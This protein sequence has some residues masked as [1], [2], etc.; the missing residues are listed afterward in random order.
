ML[1]WSV[2]LSVV[3]G[4]FLSGCGSKGDAAEKK[5]TFGTPV[6][7][8]E[9]Y[10]V[11]AQPLQRIYRS[12]GN[13]VPNEAINVYAETPGRITHIYFKEGTKVRKGALLVQLYD[14]DILAQI[15][16]LKAQ[17]DLQLLTKKR[18]EKL[19]DING[20]SRQE[21][22]NTITQ[23]ASIDADIAYNEA[24]LRK[25]QIRAPFDGII[26]LR[27]VSEGAIV[28][29]STLITTLQ[30]IDP[31]KLDFPVPE[32][33]KNQMKVGDKVYFTVSGIRDTLTGKITAIQP[34]ADEVTRTVTSRA[35]VPNPDGKLV[36]GAFANVSIPLAENPDAIL[37]PAQAIIPTTR[38]KEVAI[39]KNGKA[40]IV[41]VTTGL[42]LVD[43]IEIT[44]GLQ[45]G[46]TVITTGIMQVKEGMKVHFTNLGKK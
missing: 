1:S 39:E 42:R 28:S 6:L 15:Q 30:Q 26:G 3:G 34:S 10:I 16:K 25:L 4:L 32:R 19:L 14:K 40:K 20:I 21:V 35:M 8:A 24:Q 41:T 44:Q 17:K 23:I 5:S 9:G 7:Q 2:L 13:L 37:I 36:P 43:N 45:V 46:D 18:Q 29:T 22:D 38:D 27:M 12:S 11:K 31:L 33:Y